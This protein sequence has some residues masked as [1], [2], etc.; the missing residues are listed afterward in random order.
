MDSLGIGR[1][2]KWDSEAGIGGSAVSEST[3]AGRS[4]SLVRDIAI[5][6]IPVLALTA[7]IP[8]ANHVEP[9]VFGFPFLIAYQTFWVLL[10]PCFLYIV[11]RTRKM[12]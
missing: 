1:I 10:T 11:D 6:A 2:A 9:R 8:F 7:G 5:A 12:K 4:S 3:K